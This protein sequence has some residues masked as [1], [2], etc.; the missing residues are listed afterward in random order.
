MLCV[1]RYFLYEIEIF[2]KLII[3]AHSQQQVLSRPLGAWSPSSVAAVSGVRCRLRSP[4]PRGSLVA[5]PLSPFA[6][7]THQKNYESEVSAVSGF[8]PWIGCNHR[9]RFKSPPTPPRIRSSFERPILEEDDF[10]R[11]P[12]SG[13][14]CD[15]TICIPQR[16]FFRQ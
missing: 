4:S 1:I 7:R 15:R 9:R 5:F 12:S 2:V 10:N 14:I 6:K 13:A 16:N 3:G 8:I 11:P